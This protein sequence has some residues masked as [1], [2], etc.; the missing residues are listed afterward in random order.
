MGSRNK[1][2]GEEENRIKRQQE[3]KTLINE[4]KMELERLS[5]QL[6]SLQ[7]VEA[8]QKTIIE[9]LNNNET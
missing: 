8:E 2:E 6:Q 1:V 5:F 7:R 4:K 9:K 3:L